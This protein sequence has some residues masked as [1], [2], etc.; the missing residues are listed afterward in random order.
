MT[1]FAVLCGLFSAEA[2]SNYLAFPN[3][4]SSARAIAHDLMEREAGAPIA[5]ENMAVSE[6][7]LDR[8]G[9][10]E[11]FAYA[12]ATPFFCS[13]KGCLP[14]IYR[15]TGEEWL[16]VLSDETGITRGGPTNVSLVGMANEGFSD[17]LLG[18]VLIEWDGGSYREYQP[19]P[20][21][22]LDDGAFLA[23][24][25]G[26]PTIQTAVAEAGAIVKEPLKTFCVCLA[27]QFENAGLPQSDLDIYR[28]KLAE[29]L[30]DEAVGKL[31][32]SPKD[33]LYRLHDFELSCRIEITAD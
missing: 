18:S 28:R 6:V 31:V 33:Y 16:N 4:A 15:K 26:S 1:A 8:D 24:C 13:D 22:Q 3:T 5:L 25:N 14:R 19:P 17:I 10:P 9:T 30:S 2:A 21:T 7:D 23:A 11:I 29:Q 12:M 32:A 27:D 20:V